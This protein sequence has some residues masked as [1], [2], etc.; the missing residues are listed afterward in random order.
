MYWNQLNHATC[1]GM[2][3][4]SVL[5]CGHVSESWQTRLVVS[6][7]VVQRKLNDVAKTDRYNAAH[8]RVSNVADGT[9]YT[10]Q[11]HIS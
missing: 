11:H 9:H 4:Q 1:S 7:N 5:T 10:E 3:W 8:D 2:F 6:R